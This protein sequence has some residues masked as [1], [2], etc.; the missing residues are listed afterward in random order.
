MKLA[1]KSRPG[2]ALIEVLTT[3]TVLAILLGLGAGLLHLVLR[4]DRSGR[5]ALDLATDQA[6]LAQA[7][8]ADAHAATLDLPQMTD[9]QRI[10]FK[11]ADSGRVDYSTRPQAILRE[12]FRGDQLRQ[13][14]LYRRPPRAQVRFEVSTEADRRLVVLVIDRAPVARGQWTDPG[15]R[16]EA[17][18]GRQAR[19]VGGNR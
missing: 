17:E 18:L 19:W 4:L 5:D 7:F 2:Y 8:R 11:L 9:P 13:R 3:A 14:E 12:V 16:V 6:R 1:R 15:T 10:S